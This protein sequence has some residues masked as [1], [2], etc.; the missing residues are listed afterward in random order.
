MNIDIIATIIALMT[1]FGISSLMAIS[2]NLEYG[3]AGVPNFGQA[4]FISIG[5]YV[6]GMTYLHTVAADC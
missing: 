4:L 5:A 6:T 1:F 2:L 3:V